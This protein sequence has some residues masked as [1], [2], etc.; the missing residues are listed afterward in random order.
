[1]GTIITPKEFLPEIIALC[2]E[3]R[4]QQHTTT[5]IDENRTMITYTLPLSE[6]VLN[7]IDE[8]KKLTSGYASFDYE[9]KGY[10]SANVVKLCFHLNQKP[11][12]EFSRIVHIS[13][14]NKIAREMVL[15]LKDLIPRQSNNF[16]QS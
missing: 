15:R 10:Q 1:M 11:V 14:V 8:L 2:K 7:F 4:G 3:R 5:D 6:I 9:D 12:D 13:S 16:I